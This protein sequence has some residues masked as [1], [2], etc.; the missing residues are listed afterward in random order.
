MYK[1]QSVTI[2]PNCDIV[3]TPYKVCIYLAAFSSETFPPATS[4]SLTL[5]TSS[6]V[7]LYYN[8]SADGSAGM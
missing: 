6:D 3:P 2:F 7:S 5:T 8:I 4:S 1:I